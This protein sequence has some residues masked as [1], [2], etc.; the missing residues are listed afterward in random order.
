MVPHLGHTEPIVAVVMTAGVLMRT[1]VKYNTEK[2]VE[3]PLPNL[4]DNVSLQHAL[5]LELTF[6]DLDAL[7]PSVTSVS[8]ADTTAFLIPSTARSATTDSA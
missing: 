7:K 5:S 3:K 4:S 6:A 2:M 8:V 1:L